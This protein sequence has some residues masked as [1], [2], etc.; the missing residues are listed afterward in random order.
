MF[1]SV[2]NDVP[3]I[4]SSLARP[5]AAGGLASPSRATGLTDVICYA[6]PASDDPSIEAGREALSGHPAYPW[7]DA[8]KDALERIDVKQPEVG[9]WEWF[10]DLFPDWNWGGGGG[11]GRGGGGGLSTFLQVL[12][13]GLIVV[14][15]LV[16]VFFLVRTFVRREDFEPGRVASGSKDEEAEGRRRI[17]ALPFKLAPD[18]SNLL[19]AARYYRDRGEFGEAVKYL[20]SYQLV[21]LDRYH[22][23]RMTRGKTNRQYLR[24]LGRGHNLCPH[25]EETMKVFEDFFFGNR[26]IR[27]PRFEACWSRVSNFDTQLVSI[28][29]NGQNGT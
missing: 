5:P 20:F 3:H 8:E 11:G 29:T 24:E 17:E 9:F 14:V 27:R 15:A 25:L 7:Y 23:I 19:D 16:L 1:R 10:W 28:Q 13:Y 21:Q 6:A 22:L 26:V 18:M 4:Y 2:S 12:A